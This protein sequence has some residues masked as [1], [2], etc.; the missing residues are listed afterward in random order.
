MQSLAD[1]G[2]ANNILYP[3]GPPLLVN[4]DSHEQSAQALTHGHHVN[5][6]NK[7]Y[8]QTPAKVMKISPVKNSHTRPQVDYP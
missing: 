4:R 7:S 3:H 8:T 2:P 6:R 5:K 1:H